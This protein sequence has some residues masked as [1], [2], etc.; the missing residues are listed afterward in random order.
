[1]NRREFIKNTTLGACAFCLGCNDFLAA[2][3][4]I[5]KNSFIYKNKSELP[6][7]IDIDPCSICQ[8]KCPECWRVTNP[9]EYSLGVMEFKNFKKLLDDNKFEHI[10]LSARGEI[11]LNPELGEFIKYSKE[12]DVLLTAHGGVNGNYIPDEIAE[13]F[14][15]KEFQGLSFSIDGATNDV[16][17]IYRVGGNIDR[18]FENIRKINFYKKKYRSDFPQLTYKFILFGHNEHEIPLAKELAKDLDMQIIFRV[19]YN[20]KYSPVINKKKVFEQTGVQY[21]DPYEQFVA[22]Y[23][24][25]KDSWFYCISLWKNPLILFDGTLCGCCM[26]NNLNS[27]SKLN[28]FE[29]GFLNAMNDPKI[30]RAKKSI[31]YGLKPKSPCDK[32]SVYPFVEKHKIK[33]II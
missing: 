9:N 5:E 31:K 11:F 14:V 6:K 33:S 17:K 12:K 7:N 3:E 26:A 28:V 22:D 29:I 24:S 30:V 2:K 10:D 25:G 4:G 21:F 19:N 16:Y 27:F 1:M 32:C 18:V 13:L 23:K 20:P 15:K 8:L